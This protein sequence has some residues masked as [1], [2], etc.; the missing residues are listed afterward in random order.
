MEI[1][2]FFVTAASVGSLQYQTSTPQ[3][4]WAETLYWDEAGNNEEVRRALSWLWF[5]TRPS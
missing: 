1:F 5:A 3:W 4:L 2:F